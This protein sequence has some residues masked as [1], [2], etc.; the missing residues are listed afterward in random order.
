MS[1]FSLKNRIVSVPMK[2]GGIG[3]GLTIILFLIFYFLGR[4]P[5]IEVKYFDIPFLA[6]F[7]FFSIKEFKD[8]YNNRE[9]HFWQGISGG[10]LTYLTIAVISFLFILILIVVIDPGI[11]TNYIE[12]RVALLNENKESLIEAIDKQAYFDALEGVKKT[13]ALDLAFDDFLKKSI[14]GLFL[15]IVI[16]VILRK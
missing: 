9:L 12:S 8:R 11:T 15:T 6:I 14:I 1:F 4:N 10:T 2:Y 13:T 3:G 7:I 16:A 5:L